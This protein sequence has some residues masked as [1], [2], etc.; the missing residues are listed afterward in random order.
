M[1]LSR[2]FF[3]DL[4]RLERTNSETVR[5]KLIECHT[6]RSIDLTKVWAQ[7]YDT[8]QVPC[9]QLWEVYM[10]DLKLYTR[11]QYTYFKS[12]HKFEL[13]NATS[14]KRYRCYE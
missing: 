8:I 6:S 3:Y 1:L 2:K 14:K 13:Q 11:K 12:L 4:V 9:H 7:T 10:A 5:K